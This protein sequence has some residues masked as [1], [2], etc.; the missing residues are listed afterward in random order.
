MFQSNKFS[1]TVEKQFTDKNMAFDIIDFK[2]NALKNNGILPKNRFVFSF[3]TPAGVGSTISDRDVRY[4]CHSINLPGRNIEIGSHKRYG[5]GFVEK[6]VLNGSIQDFQASF[7]ADGQGKVIDLFD[8]WFNFMTGSGKQITNKDDMFTVPYRDDVVTNGTLEVY[9][10]TNQ[11]VRV[12]GLKEIFP[13]AIG[14]VQLAWEDQ[15]S[16]Y[17]VPVTFNIF[18]MELNAEASQSNE[19]KLPWLD[20][21][22]SSLNGIPG[23]MGRGFSLSQITLPQIPQIPIISD[24]VNIPQPTAILQ[25][26]IGTVAG[27]AQGGISRTLRQ[28]LGGFRG[29]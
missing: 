27:Q 26:S 18:N 14:D 13:V 16:F 17:T 11:S 28:T 19:E 4:Y 20:Q 29:L 7:L 24:Y 12:Y 3:K 2:A 6:N 8:S 9:D 21:T 23:R 22:L 1:T 15:N 25:R 5:V 10:Y